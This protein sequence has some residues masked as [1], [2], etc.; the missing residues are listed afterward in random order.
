[1]AETTP[2][3]AMTDLVLR[4]ATQ[5]AA[6]MKSQPPETKQ[7][8]QKRLRTGTSGT[9]DVLTTPTE[10]SIYGE[11]QNIN[12]NF[13]PN[14]SIL[15]MA[16]ALSETI[17]TP[18]ELQEMG[19]VEEAIPKI[20]TAQKQLRV[21]NKLIAQLDKTDEPIPED[22]LKSATEISAGSGADYEAARNALKDDPKALKE[23]TRAALKQMLETNNAETMDK[24]GAIENNFSSLDKLYEFIGNQSAKSFGSV[25]TTLGETALGNLS[26][27]IAINTNKEGKAGSISVSNHDSKGPVVLRRDAKNITIETPAKTYS[28]ANI[29]VPVML[30]Q[31]REKN[32][33]MEIG[34]FTTAGARPITAPLGT[35][36]FSVMNVL[37]APDGKLDI[38]Q[39][40]SKQPSNLSVT[41]GGEIRMGKDTKVNLNLDSGNQIVVMPASLVAGKPIEVKNGKVKVDIIARKETFDYTLQRQWEV[42]VAGVSFKYMDESITGSDTPVKLPT[43]T[44]KKN[45]KQFVYDYSKLSSKELKGVIAEKY[46]D[47]LPPLVADDKTLRLVSDMGNTVD[48]PLIKDRKFVYA[49]AAALQKALDDAQ[50]AL[51]K[52]DKA[53]ELAPK[54]APPLPAAISDPRT[55]TP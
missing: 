27:R 20:I 32:V 38:T 46:K 29:N 25:Q 18:Q 31:F 1:M 34:P 19:V 55:M 12:D 10:F 40:A 30:A 15:R 7:Q 21:N 5:A 33:P 8:E 54:A 44:A 23:E 2:Y 9:N 6:G 26:V 43:F 13:D 3:T 53:T 28:T 37:L 49:D 48:I 50:K 22:M 45:E 16:K 11:I 36:D 51:E 42:S 17:S 47:V 4:L 39:L 41:G 14:A 52:K 24:T 35:N